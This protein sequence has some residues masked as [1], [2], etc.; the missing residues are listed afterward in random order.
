MFDFMFEEL[1]GLVVVEDL[2]VGQQSD[3]ALLECAKEPLNFGRGSYPVID[4]QGTQGAL[5][6]AAGVLTVCG[7]SVAKEA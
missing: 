3:Q 4:S 6:L 1:V 2:L 7:G 5:E